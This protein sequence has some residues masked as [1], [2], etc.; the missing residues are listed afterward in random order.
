MEDRISAVE[1]SV[2]NVAQ[3]VR[4]QGEV[5][6]E[7]ARR[8]GNLERDGKKKE[9]QAAAAPLAT[10][11]VSEP[12][13]AVQPNAP[14]KQATRVLRG[15]GGTGEFDGV[16][17]RMLGLITPLRA[18]K[19]VTRGTRD[20][21]GITHVR[22][23]SEREDNLEDDDEVFSEEGNMDVQDKETVLAV[24]KQSAKG[25]VDCRIETRAGATVFM[26]GALQF[27]LKFGK[28]EIKTNKGNW[29]KDCIDSRLSFGGTNGQYTPWGLLGVIRIWVQEINNRSLSEK[30]AWN[31]LKPN[32]T[33]VARDVVD[34]VT[35]WAQGV[36]LLFDLVWTTESLESFQGQLSRMRQRKGEAALSFWTRFTT[37]HA[38]MGYD[39]SV[40]VNRFIKALD[41]GLLSGH[42]TLSMDIAGARE[43]GMDA[44]HAVLL[45]HH[46]DTTGIKPLDSKDEIDWRQGRKCGSCGRLGHTSDKCWKKDTKGTKLKDSG[47]S[48]NFKSD[49]T[50]KKSDSKDIVCHTCQKKGHKAKDCRKCEKCGKV[51]SIEAKGK[52]PGCGN[53]HPRLHNLGSSGLPD[54]LVLAEKRRIAL[55]HEGGHEV[56]FE[57][58]SG[59]PAHFLTQK[60]YLLLQL[61][62]SGKSVSIQ[63]LNGTPA[64]SVDGVVS[65]NF[66]WG[67]SLRPLQV[68][69]SNDANTS[70]LAEN[71]LSQLGHCSKTE[72]NGKI[73]DY[74]VAGV[75]MVLHED[76]IW[77]PDSL[78]GSALASRV[79]YLIGGTAVEPNDDTVTNY[80]GLILDADHF[81]MVKGDVDHSERNPEVVRLLSEL[82]NVG[83]NEFQ[84]R[85]GARIFTKVAYQADMVKKRTPKSRPGFDFDIK[86]LEGSRPFVET[87]R[88]QSDRAADLYEKWFDELSATGR[89]RYVDRTDVDCISN[90]VAAGKRQTDGTV[91]VSRICH[92]S[93]R[94][95]SITESIQTVF[96]TMLEMRMS[97]A[98]GVRLQFK[99]DV[100][101]GFNNVK[102]T[103]NAARKLGFWEILRRDSMRKPRIGRFEVMTFGPKNAPAVFDALM[104]H[105]LTYFEYDQAKENW[106]RCVDDLLGQFREEFMSKCIDTLLKSVERLSELLSENDL[107]LSL[108]KTFIGTEV[109]FIGGISSTEGFKADPDRM[110]FLRELPEPTSAKEL[111]SRLM[112]INFVA[113]HL[114]GIGAAMAPLHELTSTRRKFVFD[115]RAREHWKIVM[116]I[117]THT[118]VLSPV[119]PTVPALVF[120]DASKR[121]GK[122]S[123]IGQCPD[124]PLGSARELL[125]K[126]FPDMKIISLSSKGWKGALTNAGTI[127]KEF[128]SLVEALKSLEG[129]LIRM[130]I[131]GYT[132]HKPILGL[133]KLLHTDPD[134]WN[135]QLVRML[136]YVS[137]FDAVWMHIPGVR[138]FGDVFS[139]LH[140]ML[141]ELE[142]QAEAREAVPESKL[143]ILN[144]N[145]NSK[146]KDEG[147]LDS[148]FIGLTLPNAA[149]MVSPEFEVD[150]FEEIV[151]AKLAKKPVDERFYASVYKEIWDDV[152]KFLPELELRGGR[153]FNTKWESFYMPIQILDDMCYQAHK[154]PWAGH[155]EYPA[156]LKALRAMGWRPH[157]EAYLAA[158]VQWCPQCTADSRRDS[159][160]YEFRVYVP[161]QPMG[162]WY[163]DLSGKMLDSPRGVK[164]AA[165]AK[166]CYYNVVVYGALVSKEADV[167]LSWIINEIILRYGVFQICW[168]DRGKEFDNKLIEGVFNY[169]GIKHE[170]APIDRKE[171]VGEVEREV[172]VMKEHLRRVTGSSNPHWDLYL[173]PLE[174]ARM[175]HIPRKQAVSAFFLL[176]GRNPW[177]PSQLIAGMKEEIGKKD[178]NLFF[179]LVVYMREMQCALS[180]FTRNF[181]TSVEELNIQG[182]LEYAHL[183]LEL[184]PILRHD[185]ELSSKST[186]SS[187]VSGSQP[188]KEK[189]E[190]VD[191]PSTGL[192]E[193]P[194]VQRT[195][196]VK[197]QV[198]FDLDGPIDLDIL[199]ETKARDK[200][201]VGQLVFVK[202]SRVP[203]G[204]PRKMVLPRQGPFEVKKVYD[205]F[206]ADLENCY[207][208]GD[209]INRHFN[210]LHFYGGTAEDW[211]S[212]QEF[213]ITEIVAE[214]TRGTRKGTEVL[215]LCRWRG[216]RPEEDEW[217]L[218]R[219]IYAR[220]LVEQWKAQSKEMR[221]LK[222]KVAKERLQGYVRQQEEA[223]QIEAE[224]K[225]AKSQ[226]E[227][228]KMVTVYRV[229]SV[230]G[231][232]KNQFEVATHKDSGPNDYMFVKRE[233]VT[234]P[235]VLDAWLSANKGFN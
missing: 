168:T 30:A 69:L 222:S 200:L 11:S 109:A 233:N 230:R 84:L 154:A 122:G 76:G 27:E 48:G 4:E 193:V 20:D 45:K 120:P 60:D 128:D 189:E 175:V 37:A 155:F 181:R 82:R 1:V 99:S 132:D 47:K 142:T 190:V 34:N 183:N 64:A 117:L 98:T 129:F 39:Q 194:L 192:E 201:R 173:R 96:A 61:S 42:P 16:Q 211:L 54:N 196:E 31:L 164:V 174:F 40:L 138:Q 182:D 55:W 139:R 116:R 105:V 118:E 111:K 225:R 15:A 212:A 144:L 191:S 107:A 232:G 73:S 161:T 134:M 197:T 59:S 163:I 121:G 19:R 33:G 157:M 108:A 14:R 187:N 28:T 221:A 44:I 86:L 153:I 209:V 72:D 5:L 141:Y 62:P 24:W 80:D 50:E 78:T 208:P 93:V 36:L 68:C 166:E 195:E 103:E 223:A 158:I 235:E 219:D 8:L 220:C 75:K 145:P 202:F 79:N 65:T 213:P 143:T 184:S 88:Y 167:V 18:T 106:V 227:K 43:S 136:L 67:S 81:G 169:L 147:K 149:L 22:K 119:D 92:G 101:K 206:T 13:L 56:I 115:D 41:T 25:K 70:L 95:N 112:A 176:Y 203:K 7:I 110:R 35:E 198:R 3:L 179:R 135:G 85:E 49:K 102:A 90:L 170:F 10:V 38:P 162:T 114:V 52:C 66:Y 205:D 207:K 234:N 125:D 94:L 130:K 123:V 58:D 226:K 156:S 77:R 32:L 57:V 224:R 26:Y 186:E 74:W 185:L 89:V 148:K 180:G 6:N 12:V 204:E 87:F 51:M 146:P 231:R 178:A 159:V 124:L 171:W 228:K 152:N 91:V 229:I 29:E 2:T 137:Q 127:R 150:V 9:E 160:P 210:V 217:V 216:A 46:S 83:A 126:N 133:L 151:K 188:P 100:W 172:G 131:Y 177:L 104:L 218:D 215:Y 140:E 21:L 23:S 71:L 113:N 17:P 199:D 97:L 63:G 214:K 165:I 53:D